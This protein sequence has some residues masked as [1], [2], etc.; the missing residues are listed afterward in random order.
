MLLKIILIL[1][2]PLLSIYANA[3]QVYSEMLE[4]D[5][6]LSARNLENYTRL[7][8]IAG[9]THYIAINEEE[10]YH[11]TVKNLT[12]K[13]RIDT[14]T[15]DMLPAGWNI[16]DVFV[17]TKSLWILGSMVSGENLT[18]KAIP[19]VN[20]RVD[21]VNIKSLLEIESVKKK[22]AIEIDLAVSSNARNVLCFVKHAKKH[23]ALERLIFST[24]DEDLF[25]VWSKQFFNSK[26]KRKSSDN[27]VVLTNYREAFLVQRS[28][29]GRFNKCFAL[30]ISPNRSQV[31]EISLHMDGISP[32]ALKLMTD[33]SQNVMVSGYYTENQFVKR[34]VDNGVFLYKIMDG[35]QHVVKSYSKFPESKYGDGRCFLKLEQMIITAK[36]EVLLLGSMSSEDNRELAS[37]S[38]AADA[39][40]TV[41]VMSSFSETAN[42]GLSDCK[43]INASKDSKQNVIGLRYKKKSYVIYE[44]QTDSFSGLQLLTYSDKGRLLRSEHIP[45]DNTKM[46]DFSNGIVTENGITIPVITTED[47]LAWLVFDFTY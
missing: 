17:T 35:D 44:T 28:N 37:N 33:V 6:A 21:T 42:P 30:V 18:L 45:T 46:I 38:G 36:S 25:A 2:V 32:T 3:Q 26:K 47:K 13:T 24:Y 14:L 19:W 4:T 15:R 16:K 41:L 10:I 31:K 8:S 23:G 29:Y 43:M 20:G 27:N 22:D 1:I 12:G 40:N 5:I 9:V 11:L 7:S 39:G 34:P